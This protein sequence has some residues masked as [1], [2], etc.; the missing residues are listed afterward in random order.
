MLKTETHS[1]NLASFPGPAQLSVA[2]SMRLVS[3]VRAMGSKWKIIKQ[4]TCKA[5][6]KTL[7]VVRKYSHVT[8]KR[9]EIVPV[10]SFVQPQP[11]MANV[12]KLFPVQFGNETTRKV[13]VDSAKSGQSAVLVS[14]FLYINRGFSMMELTRNGECY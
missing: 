2:C 8:S 14:V 3:Y 1:V 4:F 6:G 7:L 13:N 9:F 11:I 12:P 5:C 10:C